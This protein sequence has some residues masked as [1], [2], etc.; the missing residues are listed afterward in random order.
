VC[1]RVWRVC[2]CVEVPSRAQKARD[3][4][5]RMG[6]FGNSS[7]QDA[8][9]GAHACKPAAGGAE[10]AA[11]HEGNDLGA[12]LTLTPQARRIAELLSVSALCAHA[13]CADTC[14]HD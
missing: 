11:S 7:T 4:A 13:C 12:E 1:L 3:Q 14:L 10:T 2:V 8:Q 9:Q 5:A 6:L